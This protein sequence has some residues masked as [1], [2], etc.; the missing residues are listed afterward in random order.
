MQLA[1]HEYV[2]KMWS[3]YEIPK[4]GVHVLGAFTEK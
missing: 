1:H 4:K 2:V 3:T